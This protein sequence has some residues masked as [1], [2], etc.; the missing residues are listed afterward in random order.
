MKSR[1]V[2]RP[3]AKVHLFTNVIVCADCGTS[4]WYLQN[5]KGYVC[6][7]YR[8]HGKR[9]CT[10]HSIKEEKLKALVMDDLRHLTQMSVS[11]ENVL[12]QVEKTVQKTKKENEKKLLQK[13]REVD[14]LKNE[15]R[16]FLKLLAEEVITPDE[17][18]DITNHNH[19]KIKE[20]GIEIVKLRSENNN[21][22]LDNKQLQKFFNIAESV[23]KFEE[24]TEELLHRLVEKIEVKEQG[25]IVI[26]YNFMSPLSLVV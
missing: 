1:Y 12:E 24:L 10:S 4:L 8:K 20:L 25:E 7:R 14:K 21:E 23:L 17:Y 13:E 22:A 18:R 19:E 9:A 16:K 15:N 3:K 26:H 2:K 5:R 6:G 11:K